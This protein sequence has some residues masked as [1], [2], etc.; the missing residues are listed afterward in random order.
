MEIR[1]LIIDTLK[2]IGFQPEVNKEDV[3]FKYQGENF[4]VCIDGKVSLTIY[5]TWWA[6]MDVNDSK[7]ENLKDAINQTNMSA[8]PVTLYSI[9][10]EKN[11]WGYIADTEC[12]SQKKCRIK[13]LFSLLF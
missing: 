7:I 12:S 1:N 6:S 3:Y 11:Y 9:N 8:I 4:L 10:E 2:K 13:R 5:D